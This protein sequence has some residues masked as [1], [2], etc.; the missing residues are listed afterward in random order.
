MLATD[1]DASI[2]PSGWWM[3]EKYDGVRLYWNGSKFYTRNGELVN[4]PPSITS[5]LP[6]VALDG[7]LW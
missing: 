5:Q 4:A 3:S 1:M 2:D 7:E 6:S